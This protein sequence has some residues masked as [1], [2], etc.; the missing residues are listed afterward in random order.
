MSSTPC[1]GPSNS[2]NA[3]A[4]STASR[5]ASTALTTT[6]ELTA[7]SAGDRSTRPPGSGGPTWR[8]SPSGVQRRA[9]PAS[10]T[11][12]V[13]MRP[14][15]GQVVRQP[16]VVGVQQG[17]P[18]CVA[19]DRPVLRAAPRRWLTAWR[20]TRAPARSGD[21]GGVVGGA[22]VD[23]QDLGGRRRLLR[24]RARHRPGDGVG[25]V[26]GGDDHGDGQRRARGARIIVVRAHVARP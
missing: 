6:I 24:E 2:L 8:C 18:G 10:S 5:R 7:T 3:P 16:F 20:T 12:S 19:W 26:V 17:D 15:R 25:P 1:I 4:A 9:E 23:D 14:Q 11:C 22:V 13:A 21:L